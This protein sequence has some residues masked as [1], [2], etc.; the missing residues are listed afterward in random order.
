VDRFGTHLKN[1]KALVV[2]AV[3]LPIAEDETFNVVGRFATG[4][5]TV[6]PTP[7]WHEHSQP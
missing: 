4:Y 7:T 5:L 3:V 6:I 2:A 1:E